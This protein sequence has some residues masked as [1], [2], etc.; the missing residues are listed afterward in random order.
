MLDNLLQ[1]ARRLRLGLSLIFL[2]LGGWCLVAPHMVERLSLQP[3]HQMLTVASAVLIGCFGAQAVLCGVLLAVA[4][5]DAR[6]FLVFG[7][8]GSI[9]FFVFN[10]YFVFV[11]RMF[12][13]WMLL[14]FVG[15][16][17][18]LGLGLAGF[19]IMRRLPGEAA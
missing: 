14:D 8:A 17:A 3:D 19:A 9:P 2:G 16:L 12:T 10:A 6:A 11:S 5:F 15:N 4:R 13:S 1:A 18:I 7:L